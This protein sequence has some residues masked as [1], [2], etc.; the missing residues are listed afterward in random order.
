VSRAPPE[1]SR[2]GPIEPRPTVSIGS[3]K[4]VPNGRVQTQVGLGVITIDHGAGAALHERGASHSSAK[5]EE[6][7]G[8]FASGHWVRDE[9]P[10]VLP[11]RRAWIAVWTAISLALVPL[12]I[13]AMVALASRGA[14]DTPSERASSRSD[15]VP[16][17][18][19]T[20]PAAVAPPVAEPPAPPKT[21]A[22][23]GEGSGSAAKQR[24]PRK[25]KERRNDVQRRAP[26][27][28]RPTGEWAPAGL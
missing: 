24:V 21:A 25:A 26:P 10:V 27:K 1:E 19:R 2:G 3:R 6:D 22:R 8:L 23:P 11:L 28:G 4:R 9:P 13:W 7:S 15:V 18:P 16:P 12:G 5:A 20:G 17:A 14:D